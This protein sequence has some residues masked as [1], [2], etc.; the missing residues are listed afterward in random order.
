MRAEHR[1]VVSTESRSVILNIPRFCVNKRAP[2]ATPELTTTV[3][4]EVCIYCRC[5]LHSM[6]VYSPSGPT[7]LLPFVSKGPLQSYV[8]IIA[9]ARTLKC[10]GCIFVFG[11][12]WLKHKNNCQLTTECVRNHSKQLKNLIL[13]FFFFVRK[14]RKQA[15]V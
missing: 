14:N 7:Q 3:L 6:F 12:L 5:C 15:F 2:A 13:I 4:L 1:T 8:S 11:L 10:V 9:R